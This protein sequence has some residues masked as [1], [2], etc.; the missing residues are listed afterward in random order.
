[1]AIRIVRVDG[2]PILNKVCKPVTEMTDRY[3]ELIDDMFETME[4]EDGVGLAAPQVGILRRIF[5]AN[6][7]EEDK[8]NGILTQDD[9]L[10]FINPEI[11]ETSGSQTGSEGCLSI[12]GK[13]GKV[14]RPEHVK[15]KYLDI[16]MNEQIIEADGML[17]RVICHENDHLDGHLYSEFAE[18]PLQDIEYDDEETDEE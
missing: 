4:D 14:T 6:V 15:V 1:M 16:D 12:P 7:G 8:E 2:D 3:R 18:G 13:V 5:V 17:A 9:P 10:V 11:L